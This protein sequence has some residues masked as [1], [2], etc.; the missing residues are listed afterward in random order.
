MGRG[1]GGDG[2]G[3][4]VFPPAP[5]TPIVQYEQ[6]PRKGGGLRTLGKVMGWAAICA[7]VIVLGL[8]GG[9]YLWAHESV[10]STAAHSRDVRLAQ[11]HLAVPLPGRATIALV[12]GYDY[13]AN[14]AKGTP[15]RSDTLMLLRA[16][17]ERR[18]I[19]LL[20]LPRD[21]YVGIYCPDQ[22][23]K[24]ALRFRAKINSAY[25]NCGAEG[26][27]AT[28]EQLTGLPINYLITVNFHGFKEVVDRVG[29]V[30]LDIDRRYFNDHGGPTGYATINLYPGYQKVSGSDALDYVRYRHTD[31]DFVRVERQQQFVKALKQ[32]VEASFSPFS[33]PGLVGAITHN[34]EVGV[35]GGGGLSLG[36]VLSYARFAYEL[37]GGHMVQTRIDGLTGSSDVTASQDSVMAA[38]RDFLNPD[39]G[40]AAAAT[41][42]AL[43]RKPKP[44]KK[45]A[46]ASA[47]AVAKTSLTVLNGNG[48]PGSASNASYLLALRGYRVVVPPSGK[49]ANAPNWNYFHTTIYFDPAQPGAKAA[50]GQV[51][52]LFGD[53]KVE[54]MGPDIA[55]LSSGAMVVATVGQT[56]H[57]SLTPPPT[58]AQP[59]IVHE[60]PRVL[61]NSYTSSAVA[62]LLQ[63]VRRDIPFRL[64][65]PTVVEA[66][67]RPDPAMPIRAYSL[68]KGVKA[69]RLVFQSGMGDYWG[70]EETT[71]ADAPVLKGANLRRMIK[72]RT[73]DLYYSGSNLHMVVLRWRGV[74]YWVVNSLQ[75]NLS[76]ET[77]LAIATGLRPLQGK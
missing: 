46:A 35:G 61:A 28:V 52:K 65:A 4:P 67:S 29:G 48:V 14:E 36:T 66:N 31:S 33:L 18:A 21:L 5:L 32:Q 22:S 56:F 8:A 76:N 19:S 62:S 23:G 7:I 12:L 11:K 3:R 39:V 59:V 68:K 34:V 37:P 50:A 25:A 73:Y 44:A 45:P 54:Q 64:M 51:A 57:G 40:V 16:D 71:F 2:G 9:A 41:D 24:P 17:P 69:V 49:P 58:P 77:M 30:W 6:P 20:S 10:A 63:G 15:S 75:D 70:I 72:G 55:P 42:V 74:T 27:L 1:G 53:A 43:G 38:V 60:A 47:P 26:A 13:R